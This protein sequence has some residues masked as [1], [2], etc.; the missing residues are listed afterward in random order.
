M[1]ALQMTREWLQALKVSE[2]GLQKLMYGLNRMAKE[3]DMKMNIKKTKVVKVS[4]KGEG[5]INITIDGEILEQV[6]RFRYLGAL[7]TSDGRCETEIKTRIGMAKNA[8]NQRKELLSKNL[9]KDI[10]KGII[11]AIIWS[12]ALYAA[13]T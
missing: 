2:G 12:V 8:F 10:K 6:E 3:Y 5:V 11:K 7:I 4:R 1:Y 9:N 13:E